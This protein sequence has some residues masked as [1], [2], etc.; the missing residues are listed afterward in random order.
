MAAAAICACCAMLPARTALAV[1]GPQYQLVILPPHAGQ[2]G[3]SGWDVNNAGIVVGSS[4]GFNSMPVQWTGGSPTALGITSGVAFSVNDAGHSAGA[5]SFGG[6]SGHGFYF[7]G[8]VH[9]VHNATLSSVGA[10]SVATAINNADQVVGW[11]GPA[12]AG[13]QTGFVWHNGTATLLPS[14]GGDESAAFA[15]NNLGQVG[16]WAESAVGNNR[17]FL[18][19]D[20]NNNNS[21][22]PGEMVMLPDMGLS[23]AVN[24]IN[25]S[26]VAAGFVLSGGFQR[27]PVLW[28][29]ASAFTPLPLLPGSAEAEV[30]AINNHGVAV[31]DT[32]FMGATLWSGG[33]VYNLNALIAPGSGYTLVQ[34]HGIN[35][36]GWIVG[37]AR[38][39]VGIIDAGFLLIPVPEPAAISLLASLIVASAVGRARRI[40]IARRFPVD[41]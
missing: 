26:S 35:D 37:D 11:V 27:R 36:Q 25:D 14:F 7:D 39:P 10:F 15:I 17:A 6:G 28:N 21:V 19:T 41:R 3:S 22:N 34:A 16:G 4:R 29:N 40:D 31:G 33:Q 9:D 13:K 18:W 12:A 24:A 23:S 8:A 20:G 5:Q 32:L 30:F 2:Q 1:V 38:T